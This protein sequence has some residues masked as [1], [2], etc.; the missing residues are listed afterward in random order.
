MWST[1]AD[2]EASLR[3]AGLG[4]WASRLAQLAKHCI[5]LVPGPIEEETVAPIGTSRLGG[6]PDM[7]PDADWPI[8]PPVEDGGTFPEH[9]NHPWPLSFVA[10]IDFAELNVVHALEGFPRAGRL[11]LFCDPID[12]PWGEQRADQARKRAIFTELPA[13]RLQRRRHPQEFDEPG[14]E[15]LH[16]TRFVFKPRS[17][18]P[19]AWLLPPPFRSPAMTALRAE[20][21][22]A[23]FGPRALGAAGL[24]Y[25][26]FWHD[27]YSRH[28]ETF[29]PDGDMIH[30]VGGTAC[31]IQEAVEAECVKFA[32]DSPRRMP[33]WQ[34]ALAVDAYSKQQRAAHLARADAWQLVLQIDSDIEAGMEWGDVG[35]LYLCARKDDLTAHRFDR[36]W[37]VMQCY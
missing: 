35:R 19:T 34:R 37:M 13:D 7:P 1:R 4:D 31:S 11:L 17:L 10:Q 20:Q 29:G 15:L 32:E 21:P 24:A 25:H 30:Q 26:R 8:R 23:W 22:R 3:D 16:R 12:W 9:G 27:L 2:L 5:I 33:W 18:R 36:C 14:R 28:P 6:E